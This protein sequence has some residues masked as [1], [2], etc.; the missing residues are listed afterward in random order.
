MTLHDI[1]IQTGQVLKLILLMLLAL[2]T[3]ALMVSRVF[4]NQNQSK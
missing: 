2:A 3:V 1:P 4:I